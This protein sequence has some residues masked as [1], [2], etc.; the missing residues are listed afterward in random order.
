MLLPGVASHA[1]GPIGWRSPVPGGGPAAPPGPGRRRR[2]S[3]VPAGT[4]MH[5]SESRHVWFG[6]ASVRSAA[7]TP[8]DRYHPIGVTRSH[9]GRPLAGDDS[10]AERRNGGT[11]ER[12][13]GGTAERRNG[14]TAERRNGGTAERRNGGTGEQGNR[15]TGE[16]G[17]R[18]TAEQ[19]NRGTGERRNGG[20]PDVVERSARPAGRTDPGHRAGGCGTRRSGGQT[21]C[22]VRPDGLGLRGEGA[23]PAERPVLG[24]PDRTG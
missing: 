6:A 21:A 15:G 2:D 24:H 17:N 9:G 8:P 22:A 7:Q 14:G 11:A 19:G 5:R 20:A 3:G 16:Q 1:T 13:N 12:R 23:Q 18:G 4:R 10:E